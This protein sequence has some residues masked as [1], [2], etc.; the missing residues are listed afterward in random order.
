MLA[1]REHSMLILRKLV[2]AT[3]LRRTKAHPCLAEALKLPAKREVVEVVELGKREREVYE[4]FKRRFYLLAA[5]GGDGGGGEQGPAAAARSRGGGGGA[6]AVGTKRRSSKKK[7][8]EKEDMPGK[9]RR[10]SAGNI[11]ILLSVLRRICDHGEALLP[12]AALEVWRNPDASVL[13]WDALE[14]AVETGRSCGVC[15]DGVKNGEDGEKREVDLTVELPCGKHVVCETC[16]TPAAD[17][18][19]LTCTKCLTA[20]DASSVSILPYGVASAYSPSSKVSALLR[21]ILV[22]LRTTG[23]AS[24]NVDP[25]KRSVSFFSLISSIRH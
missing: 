8:N 14:E 15:G 3:C 22:T 23:S 18:V 20:E 16:A 24:G 4:F 5:A 12:Q 7:K 10:K 9:M 13:G 6:K 25:V 21:N 19:V 2:R 17:D 1:H 11:V